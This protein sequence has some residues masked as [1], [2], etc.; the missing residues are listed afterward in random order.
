LLL[1]SCVS[2]LLGL[3][4]IGSGLDALALS[5]LSVGFVFSVFRPLLVR[6]WTRYSDSAASGY[7]LSESPI[8]GLWFP[9]HHRS[10]RCI[11]SSA[12]RALCSLFLCSISASPLLL[13]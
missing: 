13:E 11:Y 12:S 3:P 5:L 2:D 6:D 9:L 1:A 10:V 8:L 7:R 4:G